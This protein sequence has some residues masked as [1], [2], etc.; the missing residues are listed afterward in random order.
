MRIIV[1]TSFILS[2][3]TATARAA[4]PDVGVLVAEMK[5][6]L[7]P[8]RPSIRKLT[9]R[10]SGELGETSE[11]IVGQVGGTAGTQRRILNLVLAPENLR[12]IAY[13]VQEGGATNDV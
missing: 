5:R 3:L 2:L 10:V 13:L 12:G 6:A 9:I 11:V 4:S 1:V 8:A 7:E